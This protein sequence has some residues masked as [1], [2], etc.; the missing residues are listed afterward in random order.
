ML[1]F[2]LPLCRLLQMNIITPNAATITLILSMMF[3][4]LNICPVIKKLRNNKALSKLHG[5]LQSKRA[6]PSASVIDIKKIDRRFFILH[7]SNTCRT[8]YI[9]IIAVINQSGLK[10]NFKSQIVSP[11]HI[12]SEREYSNPKIVFLPTS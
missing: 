1:K 7:L 3:I 4:F 11:S 6:M 2:T 12:I 5:N 9:E 8:K 10:G